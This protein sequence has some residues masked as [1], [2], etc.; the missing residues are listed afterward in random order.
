LAV[1]W[2]A[3]QVPLAGKCIGKPNS[4]PSPS[5]AIINSLAMGTHRQTR[6]ITGVR[7]MASP[8]TGSPVHLPVITL[9][10]EPQCRMAQARK[11]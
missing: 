10:I 1:Y 8:L 11:Q 9:R 6:V 7:I 2:E 5:R 3:P 4:L